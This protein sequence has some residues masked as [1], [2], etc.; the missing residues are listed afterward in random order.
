[1]QDHETDNVFDKWYQNPLNNLHM[2][3][4]DKTKCLKTYTPIAQPLCFKY[5]KLF[6]CGIRNTFGGK[7]FFSLF[8]F[9]PALRRKR[10]GFFIYRI[11]GHFLINNG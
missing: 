6:H 7:A 10:Y 8:L 1:M 9:N 3:I 5:N 11:T 4:K 2:F